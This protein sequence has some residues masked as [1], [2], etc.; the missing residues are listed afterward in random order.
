MWSLLFAC[1]GGRGENFGR[2]A[3]HHFRKILPNTIFLKKVIEF[4][5]DLRYN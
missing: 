4:A 2:M 5:K 3:G 1:N